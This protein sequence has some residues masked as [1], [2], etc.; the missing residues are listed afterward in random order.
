MSRKRNAEQRGENQA[1]VERPMRLFS[2]TGAGGVGDE[3]VE[4][5]H[6]ADAEDRNGEED[7]AADADRADRLGADAPDEHHVDEPHR[8]PAELGQNDWNRQSGH[9]PQL[10]PQRIPTRS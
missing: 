10:E 9:R 3:V 6:H 4:A 5:E 8:H 1:M 7:V 2:V